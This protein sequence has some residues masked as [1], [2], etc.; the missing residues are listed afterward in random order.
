MFIA[1][2]EV[3]VGGLLHLLASELVAATGGNMATAGYS[4]L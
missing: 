4:I 1:G 2:H 3:E